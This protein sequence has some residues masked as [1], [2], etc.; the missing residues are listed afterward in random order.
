MTTRLTVLAVGLISLSVSTGEA[1]DNWPQFRGETA[2]V[3]AD[4]PALPVSWG[5]DENVAWRIDCLLYT[6]P[7]PRD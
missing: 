4:N 5:P 6:S 3:V 7:S 1:Q 2:G